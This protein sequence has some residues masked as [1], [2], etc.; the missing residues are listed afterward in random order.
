DTGLLWVVDSEHRRAGKPVDQLLECGLLF[1]AP[2]KGYVLLGQVSQRL[3]D[4]AEVW[5]KPTVV[6]A[7]AEE[8]AYRGDRVRDWE[9]S[10][11]LDLLIGGL[12]LVV[13]DH[14]TEV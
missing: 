13:A 9:L 5:D 10:N 7:H 3:C 2:F 4:A 8:S 14:V 11:G 1:G 12:Y 6:L